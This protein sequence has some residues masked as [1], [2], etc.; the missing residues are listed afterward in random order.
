MHD[1]FLDSFILIIVV[2]VYLNSVYILCESLAF[3]TNE[4]KTTYLI[5]ASIPATGEQSEV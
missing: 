4:S 3:M 2:Y 5:E 1:S